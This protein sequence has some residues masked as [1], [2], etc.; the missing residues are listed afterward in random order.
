MKSPWFKLMPAWVKLIHAEVFSCSNIHLKTE[1]DKRDMN[2]TG[3]TSKQLA[4]SIIVPNESSPVVAIFGLEKHRL[5]LEIAGTS[6]AW[7][8]T[9]ISL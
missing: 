6:H 2:T 5:P 3:S 9:F 8:H 7:F 1:V 4:C